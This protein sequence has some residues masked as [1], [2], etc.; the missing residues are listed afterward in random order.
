M[1]NVSC[2]QDSPQHPATIILPGL[3]HKLLVT[4]IRVVNCKINY[5]SLALNCLDAAF[6]WK[7]QIRW[8]ISPA[9]L[10]PL[11]LVRSYLQSEVAVDQTQATEGQQECLYLW[12]AH[13]WK[14]KFSQVELAKLTLDPLESFCN[15]QQ[16][17]WTFQCSKK[18]ANI[19]ISFTRE[20][21][22]RV[23]GPSHCTTTPPALD[24]LRTNC[25][26]SFAYAASAETGLLCENNL[27]G[28]KLL[29]PKG[30]L[31]W[32]SQTHKE[33]I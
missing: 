12:E 23:Q 33:K 16:S 4:A 21:F 14:Q 29:L 27:M 13:V 11:A 15:T 32:I 24:E 1:K 8:L 2:T 6:R 20:S 10:P 3:P 18:N 7:R 9:G 28:M 17:L 26:A 25:A 19:G 5:C 22:A 31:C 30:L